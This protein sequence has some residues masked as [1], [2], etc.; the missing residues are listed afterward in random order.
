MDKSEESAVVEMASRVVPSS[1]WWGWGVLLANQG[2]GSGQ[3]TG[4][5]VVGT[6][7]EGAWSEG[8]VVREAQ[9]S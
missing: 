5:G 2:N 8:D 3:D 6:D 1:P 9:S 7:V 4:Q